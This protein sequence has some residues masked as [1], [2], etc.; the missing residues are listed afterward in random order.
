MVGVSHIATAPHECEGNLIF[1]EHGLSPYWVVSKLLFDGFDGYSGEI[2]TALAGSTW[3]VNLK[4]QKGGIAPRPDDPVDVDRL[5]EFRIGLY[6]EGESQRKANYL[7]QPRFT[8]MKHYETGDRIS[9]PFDHAS[10]AEGVN[11]HFS[12][13]NFEPKE[14][15]QL[16]PQVLSVL[17]NEGGMR[18][19]SDYFATQPHEMSNITTFER[20]VRL[21]RSMSPKVVGQSGI[22]QRYL[23]LCATE[24]GSRFEYKVDNEEIVGKNHRAVL[25]K[26]DA[27]RLISGHQYGKQVKHYHPKHVRKKDETDPLFHP[28]I[29]VLVKKSLNN[30]NAI[31]WAQKEELR[32][33]IEEA[34]INTLYWAD[35]PT[36]A[37][38]TTFVPDHHFAVKPAQSP[39]SFEQDPTPEMEA[40][41]EALLV[42]QM[43]DLCDSD[44]AVLET[45]VTDG[46][47]QHPEGIAETTEYGV[48]TI[49]RALD[50]LDGLIRNE[51][52]TVT[53]A[54]KKIEQEIA[55]IVEKTEHHIENAAGR[56]ASLLGMEARQ[57]S[58]S[59][60]QQWC[61]K[62]AAKVSRDDETGELTLRID[63]MLSRL[64]STS[65][66]RLDDV[67]H[68]AIKAWRRVG[69][70]PL[71]LRGANLEW[72]SSGGSWNSGIVGASVG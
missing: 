46:G 62:Y 54:T 13:S 38:P 22:M 69:R 60:W 12:G 45:L 68:E 5:Y 28:K 65:C 66:P 20:Y 59:A 48:S 15:Y 7:I 24:E 2:E 63:T 40:Q 8:G 53:F 31:K 27:K 41:Q 1:T 36:R 30:G 9:S 47:K 50:R 17:A 3:T 58:S 57:A 43:R 6:E 32:R 34:L 37:D 71:E 35:V 61:N 39:V 72:R 25:P 67:L 51:N 23:H 19:N 29:G 56:V 26:Q 33:E 4:Y 11:I 70:D 42:T 21:R 44:V 64:K 52:A 18:V 55:A 14:Y 49:Y 10:N 16:L